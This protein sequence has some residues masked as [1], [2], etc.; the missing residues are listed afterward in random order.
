MA[1]LKNMKCAIWCDFSEYLAM[2][3]GDNLITTT[4]KNKDTFLEFYKGSLRVE[5]VSHGHSG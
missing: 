5:R 1:T 3:H 2:A 4:V